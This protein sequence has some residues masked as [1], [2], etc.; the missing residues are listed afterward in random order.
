MIGVSTLPLAIDVTITT[1]LSAMSFSLEIRT[2]TI[3]FRN[4]QKV[5]MSDCA[6]CF[7]ARDT[8]M[9]FYFLLLLSVYVLLVI[10]SLLSKKL[11]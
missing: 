6:Q 10:S 5:S 11:R 8:P 2:S 4:V 7:G 1:D 9:Y 3:I